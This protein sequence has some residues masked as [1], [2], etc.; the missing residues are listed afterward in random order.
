MYMIWQEETVF[1]AKY[2]SWSK[3]HAVLD[4][5][6]NL[7]LML[8]G[9]HMGPAQEYR[10]QQ[11]SAKGGVALAGVLV[12]LL[13]AHC[14]WMLRTCEMMLFARRECARRQSTS[15]L[16]TLS[17]VLGMFSAALA[18]SQLDF[19]DTSTNELASDL[20]ALMMWLGHVWSLWRK[21]L[22]PLV[23]LIIPGPHLDL[24]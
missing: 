7:L 5:L 6:G 12:P 8:A 20:A 21:A 24:E 22:R 13:C 1:R 16:V 15:E 9:V 2:R 14:L 18:L 19:G 11:A 10:G 3:V 17:H 4:V 23:R